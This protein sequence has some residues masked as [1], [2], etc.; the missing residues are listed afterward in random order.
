MLPKLHRRRPNDSSGF[1]H[2]FVG[3]E[4]RGSITGLHNWIQFYL[5]EKKGLVNYLGWTGKQDKHAHDD[6]HV[7][8]VKFAWEDDDPDLEV[9]PC[10]TM[11]CGS[12]IEFEVAALSLAFLAGNQNG[13]NSVKLGD[14]KLRVVCHPH[15]KRARFGAHVGT[16]YFEI[17]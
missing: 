1:E 5:E 3:E 7:V 6:V 2:V 9:K 14:E 4:S 17:A 11:L 8:T 16:A 12:T 13:D 15:A 10:S